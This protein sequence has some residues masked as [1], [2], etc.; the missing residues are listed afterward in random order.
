MHDKIVIAYRLSNH[1]ESIIY[2]FEF[3]VVCSDGKSLIFCG[4]RQQFHLHQLCSRLVTK[5]QVMYR[6][7]LKEFVP[8]EE[9][10]NKYIR[11]KLDLV[12]TIE[13]TRK[14]TLIFYLVGSTTSCS[15]INSFGILIVSVMNP[16]RLLPTMTRSICAFHIIKLLCS[17]EDIIVRQCYLTQLR[18]Y[19]KN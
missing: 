2:F 15:V 18:I 8:W 19:L 11:G 7:L 4:L 13:D 5:S 9:L 10:K 17:I 6:F 3:G 1:W 14:L 12:N 16:S